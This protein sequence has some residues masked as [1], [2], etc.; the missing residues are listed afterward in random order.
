MTPTHITPLLVIPEHPAQRGLRGRRGVSVGAYG[1][2]QATREINTPSFSLPVV[3]E[4]PPR[5]IRSVATW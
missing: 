4:L 2:L 3:R 5:V 1:D